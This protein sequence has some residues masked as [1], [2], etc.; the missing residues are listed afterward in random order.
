MPEE[1]CD[2]LN[3]QQVEF[4]KELFET[5]INA[6]EKATILA[7]ENLKIR[8]ESMNE[9]RN[10]MKDQAGTFVSRTELNLKIDS[11][12]K[13]KKDTFALIVSSLAVLLSI[14]FKFL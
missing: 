12:E 3:E 7:N 13:N 4:L 6:I 2:K 14:L 10:Q 5:K 11:V 9:F 8:L 1:N